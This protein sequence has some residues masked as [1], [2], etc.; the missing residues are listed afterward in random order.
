MPELPEVE[1]IRRSLLPLVQGAVID[2]VQVFLA[3]AVKPAP[4]EFETALTGKRITG[5]ARRGKY[6]L[7]QLDSGQCLAFHLR[8]AGRLVWQSGT[9]P[10]AKHTTLVMKLQDGKSLHFV[11][12][13][14]FGTAVLFP[15]AAPPAGLTALGLEP[16]TT[17]KEELLAV[18]AKAAARRSGPVKGLLLD[19]Q[20][21]AGLGNIYADEVLFAAG[22]SPLRPAREVT[23]AEWEKIYDSMVRIL[24]ASLAHRGTSQRD[25]VDG[26]G[27]AGE[28]QNYL[29]VYG[30][31]KEPCVNCGA[32]LVYARVAGRGTHYCSTCQR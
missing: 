29:K 14:K 25:Y 10:L 32:Q 5:L 6:L 3:K 13:R 31:K 19:Q 21:L 11:D 17:E 28:F 23:R 9:A 12:P 30:R 26:R 27:K 16:L 4:A 22:V 20:V 18:L 1:T 15:P 2:K 8:M 24:N 7:F